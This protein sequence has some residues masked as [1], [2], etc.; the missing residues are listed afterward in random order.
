MKKILI[1]IIGLLF[2]SFSFSQSTNAYIDLDFDNDIVVKD[3][4]PA[5]LYQNYYNPR[6]FFFLEFDEIQYCNASISCSVLG[7]IN[8]DKSNVL[9]KLKKNK[10]IF[11]DT[12]SNSRG[13]IWEKG[14]DFFE[15]E[16]MIIRECIED[17]ASEYISDYFRFF[18]KNKNDLQSFPIIE[19]NFIN[20]YSTFVE[21]NGYKS[22]WN[23]DYISAY[24]NQNNPGIQ[25]YYLVEQ[26]IK[27]LKMKNPKVIIKGEVI[28]SNAVLRNG[29][30]SRNKKIR[31]LKKGEKVEI[32]DCLEES[33][34]VNGI[35]YPWIKVRTSKNEEGYILGGSIKVEVFVE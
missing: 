23:R 31:N 29:S 2:S 4:A 35:S 10:M 1:L 24:E 18:I 13:V 5:R 16:N 20:V 6:E 21:K 19:I 32:L 15:N 30:S 12:A 9:E 34:S 22:P 7:I 33:E 11:I 14:K 27:K 26:T 8:K 17:T 28:E 3:G 25:F